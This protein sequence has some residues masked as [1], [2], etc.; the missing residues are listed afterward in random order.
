MQVGYSWQS[1]A[2]GKTIANI[3][4][5]SA[6]ITK[7]I[8]NK[9]NKNRFL[10]AMVRLFFYALTKIFKAA[11]YTILAIEIQDLI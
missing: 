10:S 3:W 9:A 1:Q 4:L 11:I 2:C 8:G 7:Q 6:Q 5:W